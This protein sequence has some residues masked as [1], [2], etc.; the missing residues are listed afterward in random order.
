MQDVNFH[1]PVSCL[2]YLCESLVDPFVGFSPKD[3]LCGDLNQGRVPINPLGQSVGDQSYPFELIK[4]KTLQF[5]ARA[6]P[7]LKQEYETIPKVARY[8]P[9]NHLMNP[10]HQTSPLS[11]EHMHKL[12]QRFAMQF[13]SQPPQAPN[14]NGFP[15]DE[16]PLGAPFMVARSRKRRSV[17]TTNHHAGQ[18][19]QASRSFTST[20]HLSPG[21]LVAEMSPNATLVVSSAHSSPSPG[22]R[23]L[24]LSARSSDF[25]HHQSPA[26]L[27][28]DHLSA[29]LAVIT[30]DGYKSVSGAASS[31]ARM[32]A[33]SQQ[34]HQEK[35]QHHLYYNNWPPTAA[36]VAAA[37]TATSGNNHIVQ[38]QTADFSVIMP[39]SSSPLLTITSSSKSNNNNNEQHDSHQVA[40]TT[41]GV[42]SNGSSN[43]SQQKLPSSQG[44]GN[45]NS[46]NNNN[47][48]SKSAGQPSTNGNNANDRHGFQ[49]QQQVSA[50]NSSSG[51]QQLQNLQQQQQQHATIS[52]RMA[53]G[54]QVGHQ[55]E[56]RTN[57]NN[58]NNHAQARSAASEP[59]RR[60]NSQ[61][62]SQPTSS[63]SSSSSSTPLAASSTSSVSANNHVKQH[64]GNS[65]GNQLAKQDTS[66]KRRL[67]C[68]DSSN[69][70]TY[71]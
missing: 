4:N 68:G 64:G 40:P 26:A 23:I 69:G 43:R 1:F 66:A 50:N 63:S 18:S 58:N 56:Q 19:S 65:N 8:L 28:G 39:Q 42:A 70:F 31:S 6:L 53:T 52:N 33:N 45:S 61:Q 36:A 32:L 62:A 16:Y 35:S 67:S 3:S 7:V 51:Q 49:H 14:S 46:N 41:S 9:T 37:S 47:N 24:S 48:V 20:N 15:T 27:M 13:Q 54:E 10:T 12:N 71:T 60:Q 11:S 34:Q 17:A 30:K 57:N 5:L 55:L 2:L 25:Q 38:Q 22:G 29:P 44:N 59:D 21:I